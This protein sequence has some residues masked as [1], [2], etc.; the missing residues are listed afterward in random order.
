MNRGSH[1]LIEEAA[2]ELG[3]LGVILVL[4]AWVVQFRV[5]RHIGKRHPMYELRIALEGAVLAL[6]V[7]SMFTDILYRKYT[8][9]AFAVVILARS[10]SLARGSP[11]RALK[12]GSTRQPPTMPRRVVAEVE[13]PV[14]LR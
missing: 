5:L 2:I 4:A 3:I 8:W 12:G 11:A 9:L 1:N 10:L 6:F 14:R 7:A 13:E